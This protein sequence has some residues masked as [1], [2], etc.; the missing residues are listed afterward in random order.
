[1]T[2]SSTVGAGA[3]YAQGYRFESDRVN[4]KDDLAQLVEQYSDTI[5][6]DSSSLS[7]ITNR[8]SGVTVNTP[9]SYGGYSGSLPDCVIQ[10]GIP[11]VATVTGP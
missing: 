9:L 1:M 2:C 3:L 6:V 7:V 4:S 10:A 8:R 5:Q 11:E